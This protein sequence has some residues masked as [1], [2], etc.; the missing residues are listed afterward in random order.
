MSEIDIVVGARLR[1]KRFQARLSLAELAAR[2]GATSA[3]VLRFEDG[4]E[5]LPAHMLAEF[6]RALEV[7][8]AEIFALKTG[9]PEP[10]PA[11]EGDRR[12]AGGLSALSALKMAADARRASES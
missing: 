10:A 4:Q 8:P 2:I 3:R 5:R 9:K 7:N 12:E 11:H 6:C 1:E